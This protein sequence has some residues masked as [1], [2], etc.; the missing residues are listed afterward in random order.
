MEE[1]QEVFT[2]M[3]MT[4]EFLIH[5]VNNTLHITLVT[6]VEPLIFAEIAHGP[7]LHLVMMDSVL[8]GLSHTPTSMLQTTIQ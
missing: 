8:A 4:M 1:T 3:P 2:N 5:L 6:D 7:P